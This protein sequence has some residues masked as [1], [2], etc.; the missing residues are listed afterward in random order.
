MA[1]A[2]A[3]CATGRQQ[4][5]KKEPGSYHYQMGLS[6]LGER[7]Y[8]NALIELT[9]AE[10]FD[11][12]NP[13]LL[14]NL[15]LAY[16]GK[17]RFALAEQK[18]QQ[19]IMLKQNYSP[20]R[21]DLGV[22]Y[23]E[24]KRWDNAIQQFKIVKD[25]IFYQ[26]SESA[27]INLGLA[28]LGKGDYPKALEEL[29]AVIVAN[30]RNPVARLSLGRVWFAMDK[31]EQAVAEYRK[32]LEIFKEFGAAYYYLGLAQLKQNNLDAARSSFNEV[33]RII[34]DSELGH[35]SLGYLELL[36]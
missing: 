2:V 15:G 5:G 25:D 29:R 10:K 9:E 18:L 24:L 4:E 3:G 12:E 30:P 13:E 35:A 23:L 11:P 17:K 14:Y 28:Y 36:K 27:A 34:P 21:N 26:D 20:A 31:T 19:A 33:L 22:V 16:L 7:N 32:A 8:T 1:L 6:Y